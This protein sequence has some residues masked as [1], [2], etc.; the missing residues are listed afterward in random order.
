MSKPFSSNSRMKVTFIIFCVF[1]S[2]SSAQHWCPGSSIPA[3]CCSRLLDGS[4][5]P[6]Y[7]R[8][9]VKL[10]KPMYGY[11]DETLGWISISNCYDKCKVCARYNFLPLIKHCIQ[12]I[13]F[14]RS[15]FSSLFSKKLLLCLNFFFRSGLSV[16]EIMIK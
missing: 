15:D 3:P 12:G 5:T 9:D 7:A 14:V 11:Q 16:S 8:S 2:L 10:L 4:I 1:I 6:D 13:P